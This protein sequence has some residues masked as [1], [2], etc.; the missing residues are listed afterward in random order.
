MWV[1]MIYVAIESI[2][3]LEGVEDWLYQQK[4]VPV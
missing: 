3:I 2:Q 4:A 1:F